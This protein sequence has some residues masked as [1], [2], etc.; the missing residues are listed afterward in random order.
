MSEFDTGTIVL[1]VFA[2][3]A[4]GI[5]K[6]VVGIGL[7]IVTIAILSSFLPLPLVLTLILVP[8]AVTNLW[9][10]VQT[11]NLLVPLRRFWPMTAC[12]LIFV[13]V[14]AHLVVE[15]DP[16][17]LYAVLGLVVIF[18]SL[19]DF[20]HPPGRL[21][22]S[23]EIWAGPLAGTLGGLLGGLSTIWGPPMTI[24]FM[25]LRLSKEEFVQAVGLVWF[26]GSIP[27][28]L[29]F[30]DNG[31]LNGETVWLSLG[32]CPPAMVGLGLGQWVRKRIDQALFRKALLFVLFVIGLNLLRRAIF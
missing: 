6:G 11:G 32:A 8:I 24:Y 18:F 29:A 3:I 14:S 27:L 21:P 17:V 13:W 22:P 25:L 26:A 16:R 23:A 2:L 30:V 5:V 1:V 9:Q 31:L 20:I 19:S 12:L 7:P 28:V 15:L 10:A 4:G